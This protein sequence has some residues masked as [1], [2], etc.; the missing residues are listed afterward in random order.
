M[1]SSIAATMYARMG[2]SRRRTDDPRADVEVD[3][4]RIVHSHAFRRLQR[5]TQIVGLHSI[6]FFRTR[7]AEYVLRSLRSMLFRAAPDGREIELVRAMTIEVRRALDRA[8]RGLD[9]RGASAPAASTRDIAASGGPPAPD[10]ALHS[11]P[12]A[13]TGD[14][15]EEP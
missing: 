3:R 13:T 10:D 2:A 9:E 4:D 15:D 12:P 14:A 5:K 8:R 1:T 11:S 6:D 7:N